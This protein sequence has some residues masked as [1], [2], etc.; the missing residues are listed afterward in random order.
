MTIAYPENCELLQPA[1]ETSAFFASAAAV[2]LRVSGAPSGEGR[3]VVFGR[4]P[5]HGR[6]SSGLPLR[7]DLSHGPLDPASRPLPFEGS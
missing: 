2:L 4:N 6:N 3:P 1:R 5:I 7:S